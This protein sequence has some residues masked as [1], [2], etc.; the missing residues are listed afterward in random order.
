MQMSVHFSWMN[1]LTD[2][3]FPLKEE[4][5]QRSEEARRRP[6]FSKFCFPYRKELHTVQ[7]AGFAFTVGM[8]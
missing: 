3:A 6:G 2:S 5:F 1:A 4:R 7:S 8:V